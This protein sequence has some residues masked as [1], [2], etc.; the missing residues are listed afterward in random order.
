MPVGH[1]CAPVAM[2]A[3]A[4]QTSAA[5]PAI[6]K[7]EIDDHFLANPL[8][9]L[10]NLGKGLL[11]FGIL[12]NRAFHSLVCNRLEVICHEDLD[13]IAAP[14]ELGSTLP[15]IFLTGCTDIPTTVQAIKAGADDF[16]TKPVT[17]DDL[18]RAIEKAF[19]HHQTLRGLQDK[20]DGMRARLGRL[21]PRE[22][23]VFDLV[24]RGNVNKQIGR[25]L[26]A[27]ERTIKVHRHRVMEKCRPRL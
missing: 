21:T 15:I 19:A 27:T 16:L 11:A 8:R 26:G 24:V 20:L 3:E 25:T 1:N 23:Q 4:S 17:S 5:N 10:C 22:R 7:F 12:R 14:H 2:T 13:T 6:S 18:F 9:E